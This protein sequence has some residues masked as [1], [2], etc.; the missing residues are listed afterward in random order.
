MTKPTQYERIDL[1]TERVNALYVECE[2]LREQ[3]DTLWSAVRL[4]V[5]RWEDGDL[6][7]A[8]RHADAVSRDIRGDDG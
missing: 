1:L 7:E 5:D 6:A 2:Q 4:V 3:R 8:V